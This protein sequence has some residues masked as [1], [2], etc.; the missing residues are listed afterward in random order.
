MQDD[1]HEVEH[2]PVVNVL[3]TYTS[4]R[5]TPLSLCLHLTKMN[6]TRS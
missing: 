6:H 1:D 5:V 3:C 4:K 2:G